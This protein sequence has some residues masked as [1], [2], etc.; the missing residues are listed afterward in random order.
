[1]KDGLWLQAVFSSELR[2]VPERIPSLIRTPARH[3]R[4]SGAQR[5]L[6]HAERAL[7]LTWRASQHLRQRG[8]RPCGWVERACVRSISCARM[9][10]SAHSCEPT[11]FLPHSY[12]W[13]SCGR[14]A[15]ASSSCVRHSCARGPFFWRSSERETSGYQ[16]ESRL[17]FLA[18]SHHATTFWLQPYY[19]LHIGVLIGTV[20]TSAHKL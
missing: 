4:Q 18:S 15:C 13:H 14:C 10:A 5:P 3:P 2:C 17:F 20:A 9:R 7:Q 19:E 11:I 6:L 8:R 1:M 12:G 16:N